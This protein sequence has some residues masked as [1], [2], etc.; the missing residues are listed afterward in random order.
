MEPVSASPLPAI[1]K[2]VGCWSVCGGQEGSI[3]H[4]NSCKRVKGACEPAWPPHAACK[5]TALLQAVSAH[6]PLRHT[7]QPHSL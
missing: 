7:R 4:A 1:P 3:D 6:A 5:T 2:P